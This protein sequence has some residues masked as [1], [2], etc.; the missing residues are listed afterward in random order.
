M[1]DTAKE[2]CYRRW[3]TKAELQ[4][5]LLRYA[6]VILVVLSAARLGR[7][8]AVPP[9]PREHLN[10]YVAD[11]QKNPSDD[12]LR[13]K[14]IKLALTLDPKPAIPDEAVVAAAKAKTIFANATAP[15]DMKAAAA[16]FSEASQRAPWVP[17][18]YFNEGLALEKAGQF[19]DAIRA[20]NFYLLAAPN[21]SDASDVRGRIEGIRYAKEKAA[22]DKKAEIERQAKRF[23]GRWGDASGHLIVE[24]HLDSVNYDY[25][26]TGGSMATYKA[27]PPA[28]GAFP[29]EGGCSATIDY[30]VPEE[31]G[32]DAN[33]TIYFTLER[34]IRFSIGPDRRF[35]DRYHLK[36]SP[37]G[38]KLTG[39]VYDIY[40][41]YTSKHPYPAKEE[42]K[43]FNTTLYRQ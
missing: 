37:D 23:V 9:S 21:S 34:Y 27:I 35:F 16:A 31:P 40:Q 25:K 3:T 36:I 7:G 32:S 14:I 6:A 28:S 13:E 20:L 29:C 12:A 43:D 33:G 18:Y 42:D 39:T 19:D 5:K 15:D 38:S 17:D 8:Q 11:L 1:H 22:A 24:I 30:S 26:Y 10:Q 4:M 41:E 2:G